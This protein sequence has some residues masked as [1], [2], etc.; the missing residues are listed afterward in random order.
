MMITVVFHHRPSTMIAWRMI[1][2]NSRWAICSGTKKYKSNETNDGQDYLQTNFCFSFR[3]VHGHEIRKLELECKRLT[4][5]KSAMENEFLMI[6]EKTKIVSH[7]IQHMMDIIFPSRTNNSDMNSDDSSHLLS[8]SLES[9]EQIDNIIN[10]NLHIFNGEQ[11]Q[12]KKK[13]DEQ[14]NSLL[15]LKQDNHLLAKQSSEAQ[16]L[17]NKT[18]DYLV[19]TRIDLFSQGHAFFFFFLS[20]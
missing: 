14:E 20:S 8:M 1:S 16:T 10:K 4:Q 17:F 9:I 19:K 15:K 12:W 13:I 11:D 6:N 5:I 18:Q 7:K 3:E 2:S